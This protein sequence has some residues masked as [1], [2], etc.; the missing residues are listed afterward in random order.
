MA[1]WTQHSDQRLFAKYEQI[2]FNAILETRDFAAASQICEVHFQMAKDKLEPERRQLEV[3]KG[4][5]AA[6]Q[7]AIKHELYE[8]PH[9]VSNIAMIATRV[10]LAFHFIAFVPAMVVAT[11]GN[12]V[13]FLMIGWEFG[14]AAVTGIG[15]S[16]VA[17]VLGHVGLGP[18]LK[19]GVLRAALSMVATGLFFYGLYVLAQSRGLLGQTGSKQQPTSYVGNDA[20][21]TTVSGPDESA[22]LE[23]SVRQKLG[24]ALVNFTIASDLLLAILFATIFAIRADVDFAA[25]TKLRKLEKQMRKLNKKI[26]EIEALVKN[27][28]QAMA[29]GLRR[30]LTMLNKPATPPYFKI[31][32]TLLLF[33]ALGGMV[34]AQSEPKMLQAYLLDGSGSI[35]RR[36]A[37]SDQFRS[38]LF[39]IRSQILLAPPECRLWVFLISTDSFGSVPEVMRGW[40][41]AGRGIF[42]ADLDKA[43]TQLGSAFE[44]KSQSISP[45]SA[46]TDVIGGLFRTRATLDSLRSQTV[47]K[48]VFIWSDML[49]ETQDF[50]MPALMSGGV[51]KMIEFA[52]SNGL[53][54]DLKGY[55]IYVYGASTSGMTPR[56]WETVRAFWKAY[57]QEAGA[58]LV[59]YST[60]S[61]SQ[62]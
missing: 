11:G 20:A 61:S 55:R 34:A 9:P 5:C 25:W 18:L 60:E 44:S 4:E 30:G 52:K 43:R 10:Y 22:S 50:N 31:V 42:T 57:F 1:F 45:V 24:D 15:I 27:V 13:T 51:E 46:G 21:S 38:Y 39:G 35:G 16:T 12:V 14:W 2:G 54:A 59:V 48:E 23:Q 40:T 6:K 56:I 17:I 32:A 53:I 33:I 19:N 7:S 28:A 36:N 8:R 29:I 47:G 62:R 37:Q 3:E 26:D 49:N 58:T 41:P